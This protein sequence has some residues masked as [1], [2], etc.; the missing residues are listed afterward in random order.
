MIADAIAAA[1]LRATMAIEWLTFPAG[2]VKRDVCRVCYSI[3]P[4][5]VKPIVEHFR[6]S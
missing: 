3:S 2:V 6:L 5:F 1:V 4:K